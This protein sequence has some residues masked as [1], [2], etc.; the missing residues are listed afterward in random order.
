M[1]KKKSSVRKPGQ[2]LNY[3]RV[4]QKINE[5]S[6]KS[7]SSLLTYLKRIEPEKCENI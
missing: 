2:L 5:Y 1:A 7:L 3:G 4:S 6:E